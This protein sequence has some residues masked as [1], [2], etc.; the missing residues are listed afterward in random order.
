MIQEIVKEGNEKTLVLLGRNV[1]TSTLPKQRLK[2]LF[3]LLP[4]SLSFSLTSVVH[5]WTLP[6]G[7]LLQ[8]RLLGPRIRHCAGTSSPF[9]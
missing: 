7:P 4:P 5:S 1:K 6:V 8:G 9:R 3:T 2:E